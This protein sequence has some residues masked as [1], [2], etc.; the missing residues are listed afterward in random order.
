MS[1]TT[2]AQEKIRLRKYLNPFFKGKVTDAV[3]GALAIP[4]SYLVNSVDAV[5]SSLYITTAQQQYLDLALS[6][7][8][9]VRDPIIGLGDDV[10]REIG[11][12]VKNRKQVRDLVNKI[13]DAVFGD[14]FVKA[15]CSAQNFEPY[16]LQD[17]DTLIVNFDGSHTSIITFRSSEF[18]DINAAT[19]QE[20]ANAISV[21]LS[22]LGVSGSAI[23]N[24]DGNGNYVQL[25]SDTI[26]ASSSIT[27]KGGRAQ[28][29]LFF[30]ASVPAG[31]N[32]STQWTISQQSGGLLR[33]TWT[34]GANPNTG[35]LVPG[36][37]VNIYGGGFAASDNEGTYTIVSAQG[38]TVGIA[39]FQISNP[40]GSA[41]IVTQGTDTAIQ[42]FTPMRETILNKA[43]YAAVYQTESNVLQ[44]FLPATTQ[45]IKRSRIGSGHLHGI[46]ESPVF[47]IIAKKGNEYASTGAADYSLVDGLGSQFLYYTW[48]NVDSGNT[49]P[50]PTGFTAIEVDINSSDNAS[51]VAQKTLTQLMAI[52]SDL[53]YSVVDNVIS[54]SNVVASTIPDAG[55][56]TPNT[57]GPYIFDTSQGFTVGLAS[58]TLTDDLN[59]GSSHV[60]LIADSTDFP[61][62][63]GYVVIGYGTENQELIPYIATPSSGSLLISPAYTVQ[64]DHPAGSSVIYVI[65]KSPVVLPSDGSYYQ[66]YLTDSASGRVYAEGLIEDITAAGITVIY[67]VLFPNP[68]GLAGWQNPL[69]NEVAYVYGP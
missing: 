22:N 69:Q 47:Q 48:F 6:N 30:P 7:Y 50:S 19:A 2:P 9:I 14:P 13:L 3:L 41:G 5:N 23:V 31:G 34:G 25:I 60:A 66:L 10:F 4:S 54:F 52:A 29:V 11:I 42:F 17:Q 45:V 62:S 32:F 64:L 21:N 43:Y 12:A 49:D 37:Y 15:T 38:G 1:I 51:E 35:A 56:S 39:Y 65:Q 20:V 18:T 40:T 24:N 61:D 68:I 58:T 46:T 57:L 26:G 36:E 67:T 55:E 8:G 53:T 27:V 59:G 44:I 33:F 16:D 28:N 63:S